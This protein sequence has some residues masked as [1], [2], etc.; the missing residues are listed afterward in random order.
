MLKAKFAPAPLCVSCPLYCSSCL[1][2]R[3]WA[4]KEKQRPS[5]DWQ[6]ICEWTGEELQ[7]DCVSPV[8]P[9]GAALYRPRS[10]ALWGAESKSGRRA[11]GRYSCCHIK[12]SGSA[13][14]FSYIEIL[15]KMFFGRKKIP[16]L[17]ERKRTLEITLLDDF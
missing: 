16:L 4:K 5:V 2:Q 8:Q 3:G 1:L 12:Q 13:L 7:T 10:P 6:L 17:K 14:S 11:S 15:G 9:P